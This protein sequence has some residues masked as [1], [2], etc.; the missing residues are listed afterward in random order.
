MKSDAA[1]P[2]RFVE[3][4]GPCMWKTLHAVA[5]ASPQ[6]PDDETRMQYIDFFRAVGNVIPCPSC[7]E[8]YQSYMDQHPI[9]A[10]DRKSLAR[11]V[12]DLH[13]TVNRRKGTKSPSFEEVERY[14][15]GW[16]Q[17]DHARLSQ[18]SE[19]AKVRKLADPFGGRT[20][21]SVGAMDATSITR[22]VVLGVLLIGVLIA[23][24]RM[25]RPRDS[26]K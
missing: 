26:E 15:T 12:Y 24:R 7:Q 3:F 20:E 9:E 13:D 5:F 18:L 22:Y 16:S 17:E 10:S 11:W 6:H 19:E 1:Y 14:Y 8:H 21:R 4:F 2:A 23:L 25:R